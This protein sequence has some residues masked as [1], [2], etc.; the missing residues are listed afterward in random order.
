MSSMRQPLAETDVFVAGG[1]PAGLAA[2]IAAR[3]K[4]F[5][6]VAADVC[7]PPIEKP[8][9]EGLM[10]DSV[11]ALRKLGV[12]F[13]QSECFPFGGVCF[14]GSGAFVEARFPNGHGVG[15]RR[16]TLHES[17]VRRADEAGVMLLWG[18]RVSGISGEGVVVD[19][20]RIRCRWIIGADGENSAIRRWAG[21]DPATR[22][23]RRFGFRRHYCV[24]PWT[25]CVEVYWGSAGQVYITPVSG[26]E[27]SVVVISRDRH[28]RID[29]ALA[30][31]PEL[32]QRLERAEFDAERGA[33]SVSRR[34]RNVVRGNV[35]LV[36][37]GSGSVD[38]IT[39]EGLCLA[40]RQ[41]AALADA[42]EAGNLAAYEAEHR[43]LLRR[44][45]LMARLMLL[46]DRFPA[47]RHRALP[48]L[49]AQPAIFS[50]LLAAH[51][52]EQ[53]A[54]QLLMN[55]ILPL[56]LRMLAAR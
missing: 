33:V 28:F 27:I 4:G 29:E 56:G 34:L 41:A 11:A 21:L 53:A 19:G 20:Q 3:Q 55:G 43:R 12:S 35:A 22:F 50:S 32:R 54:T 24:Q 14:W 42:L 25:D 10:P 36:G 23:A 17:L 47:L 44:P 40:F 49:A 45:A 37:D 5:R 46:L 8:C 13:S 15:V 9:G 48:A 52:A 7:R 31:F 6:V 18:A 51:M 1:G 39:G 2:A 30:N 16:R 38:A 26:K